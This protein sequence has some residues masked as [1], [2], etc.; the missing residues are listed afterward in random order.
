V[1]TTDARDVA[2]PSGFKLHTTGMSVEDGARL[3]VEFHDAFV[4]QGGL[5]LPFMRRVLLR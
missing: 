4:A 1:G 3:C 5:P 2:A